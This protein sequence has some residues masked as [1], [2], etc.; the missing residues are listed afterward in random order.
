NDNAVPYAVQDMMIGGSGRKWIVKDIE[1][2]HS[3]QLA[4]PEELLKILVELVEHFQGM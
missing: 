3:P 4:K 2:G 1:T